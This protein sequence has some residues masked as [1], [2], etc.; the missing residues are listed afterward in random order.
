LSRPLKW[1][2]GG[3][4]PGRASTAAI[5][6]IV[7]GLEDLNGSTERDFLAIGEKLMS[8]R[9]TARQVAADISALTDLIAGVQGRH[10]SLALARMLEH[11]KALDTGIERSALALGQVSSLSKRVRLAFSGLRSTVSVFRTL[12]TLTRIETSRLGKTGVDFGDLASEV[13]PLSDAV[14]AS[15][16]HVVEASA[17]L[18]Q[19]IQLAAE[20]GSSLRA[21]QLTEL[22]ALIATVIEGLKSFDE[23]RQRAVELSARQ[24]AQ[25]EGL[26]QAIDSVVMSLQFHDITHQQVEHVVEALKQLRPGR[27]DAR[28]L[29]LQSAQLASTAQAFANSIERIETDLE[30]FAAR[31]QEMAEATSALLG[32][33]AGDHDSFFLQMEGH[34]N[35]ILRMLDACS[36]T[37]SEMNATAANL[38]STIAGMRE[39][40]MQIRNIEV[41]I[42][43]ISINATLRATQIGAGGDALN[44][45]AAAMLRLAGESSINTE[46]VAS[47]LDGMV[48]AASAA[49][50]GSSGTGEVMGEI[51]GA[52]AQLH[53]SSELSCRRVNEIVNLAAQLAAE[54]GPLRS[55]FSAG[56]LFAEV[57]SRTRGELEQAI[58]HSGQSG[59]EHVE[60]ENLAR[61]YTMQTE[62]DVHE[63]V[64]RGSECASVTPIVTQ[65]ARREQGDLGENVELF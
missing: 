56:P 50:S 53:T 35:S 41:S 65:E 28:V 15:G 55:G 30:S 5:A 32:F 10:A 61:R 57:V 3:K 42:Q 49:S 26:G 23:K 54:I 29:A 11:S 20:S 19:G 45:I 7:A 2:L 12:C 48:E 25:Y 40:A 47:A 9:T 44:V 14:Q 17:L 6:Q 51:R 34:F 16:E 8:F 13:I 18:D 36:T 31:V 60:L 52:V 4:L 63:S 62:R 37:Q 33:S 39:S 21:R 43:R 38:G 64:L 27:P 24:A 1:A 58:A 22:P 59:L 46:N